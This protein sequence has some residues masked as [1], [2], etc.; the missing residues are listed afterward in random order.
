MQHRVARQFLGEETSGRHRLQT[1][2]TATGMHRRLPAM[3]QAIHGVEMQPY[4]LDEQPMTAL[5]R[6]AEQSALIV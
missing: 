2:N 4:R 3:A 1:Y 6:T 5:K